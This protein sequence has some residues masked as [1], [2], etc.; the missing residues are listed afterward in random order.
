MQESSDVVRT[1]QRYDDHGRPVNPETRQRMR[2]H[3]RSSN[4]VMQAAG[5]IEET[6]DVQARDMAFKERVR[7]ETEMGLRHLEAGR[8]LLVAGVWGVCGFRR[9]I[10]VSFIPRCKTGSESSVVQQL[11]QRAFGYHPVRKGAVLGFAHGW[12][13][14]TGHGRLSGHRMAGFTLPCPNQRAQRPFEVD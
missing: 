13:W 2:D 14:T 4:E 1:G 7:R 11:F 3:I 10:L 6:A 5:I 9:R 12:C 8:V